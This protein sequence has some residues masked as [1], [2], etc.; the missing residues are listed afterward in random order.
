MKLFCHIFMMLF[1]TVLSGNNSLATANEIV[2]APAVKN[3]V[4]KKIEHWDI[5]LFNGKRI[6]YRR[7]STEKTTRQNLP[8]RLYKAQEHLKFKRFGRSTQVESRLKIIDTLDGKLQH[9]RFE[10]RDDGKVTSVTEGKVIGR[11]L[12]ITIKASGRKRDRRI[13]WK[14]EYISS[15]E[16]DRLIANQNWNQ[17]RELKKEVFFPEFLRIGTISV[18]NLGLQK[19]KWWNGS[20]PKLLQLRS[21]NTLM[22]GVNL[23][24][25]VD[26]KK[27]IVKTASPLIGGKV[28]SYRV[29]QAKALESIS[30]KELDLAIQTQI[31]PKNRLRNGLRSKRVV[32]QI[33][34]KS[35]DPSKI[36]PV[37]AGQSVQKLDDHHIN[38]T[39]Q[40]VS[41]PTSITQ[42]KIAQKEKQAAYLK[43]TLFFQSDDARVLDH[44]RRA[45]SGTT[46]PSDRAKA[47]EVYVFQKIKKKNFSS[48][49][50]SAADVAKSMEG[51][52]TEHATLLTA[53]L[54]SQKIPAR[55]VVGLIYIEQ[56]QAFGGHMWTE[57]WLGQ[58]WTPL[59][60]T[61][62]RGGIGGAHLKLSHS[63]PKEQGATPATLFVPLMSLA[64]DVAITIL[65]QE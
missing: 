21:L 4:E 22:P 16:I 29:S 15:A 6:G 7:S 40:P 49:L 12:V 58:Q 13:P 62:G 38:L 30:G 51:D 39:I 56:Q 32:Y 10:V 20:T 31:R 14:A 41:F 43:S 5:I 8:M 63:D 19:T 45:C 24:L 18:T 59:D 65:K 3:S 64:G 2:A 34:L 25:F 42:K 37:A 55:V 57:A 53:M 36:F 35:G 1:L 27:A 50:S 33:S 52:C 23:M 46:T 48:S 26:Q 60:A 61:L 11:N 47:M 54:R 28:T 17:K 9:F 44:A